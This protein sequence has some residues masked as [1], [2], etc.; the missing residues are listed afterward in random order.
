MHYPIKSNGK[1]KK[2]LIFILATT[3]LADSN[4][5]EICEQ[6]GIHTTQFRRVSEGECSD[7]K[8]AEIIGKILA[9]VYKNPSRETI[10]KIYDRYNDLLSDVLSSQGNGEAFRNGGTS[11][12]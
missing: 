9:K 11:N 6:A 12:E 2:E 5:K 1:F 8:A 3:Y 10:E 4:I 7:K